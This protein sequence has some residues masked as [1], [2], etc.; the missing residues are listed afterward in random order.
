MSMRLS[1]IVPLYNVESYIIQCLDS[2]YFQKLD[3]EEFEVIVVDDGSTDKS[4]LLVK[5]YQLKHK[6]IRIFEQKN[7]GPSVARNRA[8]KEASGKY[9]LFVD[10]DDYL[11]PNKLFKLIRMAELEDVDVLRAN[12]QTC[13]DL[14]IL[15]ENKNSYLTRLPYLNKVFDGYILYTQIFCKEFFTPLLLLN[16][17]FVL[18]NRLFF[19]EG[20]YFEDV[21]FSTRLSMIVKRA[22]YVPEIFY[23][24]RLRKGSITHSINI[25]KIKDLQY[26]IRKLYKICVE[27]DYTLLKNEVLENITHLGVYMILR[28]SEPIIY[29]MTKNELYKFALPKLKISGSLKEKIIALFYNLIGINI[30]KFL[31]PIMY[32][33]L[34]IK[35]GGKS[36]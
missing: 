14:S 25:K 1:I 32:I 19:E 9:I 10:S 35:G 27:G 24:Y 5:E 21:D 4:L 17:R 2:L 36:L 6:N 16:R 26:V 29:S 12:Y 34:K 11:L 18:N 28:L 7:A 33:K 15:E 23:V 3:E 8:I 13:S 30:V 31:Y 20:I 22:M